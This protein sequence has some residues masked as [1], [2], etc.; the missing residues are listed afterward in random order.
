MA[1]N[2][3]FLDLHAVWVQFGSAAALAFSP[4][5]ILGNDNEV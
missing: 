3:S 4:D 1:L 5:D 2:K